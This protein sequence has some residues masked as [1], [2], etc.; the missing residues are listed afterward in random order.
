MFR[1][2]ALLAGFG[3]LAGCNAQ[4]SG[5]AL[6]KQEATRAAQVAKLS[7]WDRAFTPDVAVGAAN[8]LGFKAPA[9]A[10]TGAEYRTAGGPVTIGSSFGKTPSRVAFK[11]KGAAADKIDAM[12][13]DLT[14]AAADAKGA[15]LARERFAE[16]V[17]IFLFQS[18]IDASP[19]AAKLSN[20]EAGS[21]S[22]AGAPY[23]IL[24][25][26]AGKDG[27]SHLTVTFTRTGASAS[28]N[29]TQGK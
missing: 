22:L 2:A 13:F 5:Q 12:A 26:P 29:Q 6:Q 18:K 19:I 15:A 27:M 23:Q 11:A 21:G 25:T 14:T 28:G 9:F 17:K 10:A 16:M 24:A 4:P 3:L 20:G 8:Q 1:A 7:G